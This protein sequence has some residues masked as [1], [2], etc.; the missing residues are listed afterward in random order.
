MCIR[1]RCQATS[2]VYHLVKSKELRLKG[3]PKLKEHLAN[4]IEADKGSYGVRFDKDSK[5]SKID[6]AIAL[7]I[8]SLAYDKLVEGREYVP[9]N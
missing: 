1:D 7:A 9:F 3:C 5:K 2:I 6:A 4:T 8:A